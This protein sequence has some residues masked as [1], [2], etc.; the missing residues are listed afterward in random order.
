M[1][2]G[3]VGLGNA[4]GGMRSGLG[5]VLVTRRAL[6]VPVPRQFVAVTLTSLTP[7]LSVPLKLVGPKGPPLAETRLG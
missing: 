7:R 2:L 4:G 5:I 6:L 1:D 3:V